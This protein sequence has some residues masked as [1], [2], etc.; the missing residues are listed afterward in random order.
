MLNI[1]S[2]QPVIWPVAPASGTP[3][4]SSVTAVMPVQSS[5]RDA[6]AGLNQ[7]REQPVPASLRR[8][9]ANTAEARQEAN[10]PEAAPLLPRESPD[11]PDG[12][13]SPEALEA[14]A[15]AEAQAEEKALKRQL[16]DVLSDVWKASA[17]VVDV[18]LGREA[19]SAQAV[20]AEDSTRSTAVQAASL[21][22]A[23]P[24]AGNPAAND[25]VLDQAVARLPQDVMAYDAQGNSSWAPLEAGSLLS[26]RV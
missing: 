13:P 1:S 11:S 23:L 21:A 7:G 5:A 24:V 8:G 2:T 16:Q 3:A 20:G 17:A 26:R 14:Q 9:G 12:Q 6:Q 22:V 15:K 19:A 4:V 10:M 25:A 18:V